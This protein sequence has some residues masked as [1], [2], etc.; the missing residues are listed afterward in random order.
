MSWPD[1]AR[2]PDSRLLVRA[3]AVVVLVVDDFTGQ[4]PALPPTMRLQRLQG[5]AVI[6]LDWRPRVTL[7]GAVVFGALDDLG[8]TPAVRESYRLLVDADDTLRPDQSDGYGADVPAHPAGGRSR[9]AVRLLP[10]PGYTFAPR[11]PVTDPWPVEPGRNPGR[12]PTRWSPPPRTPA[13]P[14]CPPAA[15]PTIGGSSSLGLPSYRPARSD[16]DPGHRT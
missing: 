12:S 11:L 16:C 5:G 15:A 7:G 13:L 8:G 2:E 9:V 10:G 1:A 4:P 6:E 14:R 3:K